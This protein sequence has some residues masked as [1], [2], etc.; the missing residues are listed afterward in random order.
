MMILNV[1]QMEKRDISVGSALVFQPRPLDISTGLSCSREAEPPSQLQRYV[2]DESA[3][4]I[5][6]L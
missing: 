2:L 6:Q 4:I 5:Q 1:R 3:H